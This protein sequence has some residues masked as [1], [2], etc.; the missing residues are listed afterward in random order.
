MG[1]NCGIIGLPNVG[2][3]TIFNALSNGGAEMAN[4]PF[5]TV[6]PNKGIV[7]VPDTRLIKIA[8]LL[9]KDDPIPTRIEFIDVAGLVKGASKGEGLG[10]KFLGHIREVDAIVHVV[11][12]FHTEDVAHVTGEVDP[13]RDVE[14]IKTELVLA[15]IEVLE[16]AERKQL[17]CFLHH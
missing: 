7:V 13:I 3:S 2:K 6:E 10:N 16:R 5:C 17:L 1:F 15:D 9:K 4:Y 12:C 8:E 14:I 11:R